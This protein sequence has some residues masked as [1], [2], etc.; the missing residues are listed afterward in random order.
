MTFSIV[1]F[2]ES[3][4]QSLINVIM[5]IGFRSWQLSKYLLSSGERTKI[6]KLLQPPGVMV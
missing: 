2:I 4:I 1:I 5:I 3:N 6:P